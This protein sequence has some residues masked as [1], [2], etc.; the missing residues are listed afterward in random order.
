MIRL[1]CFFQANDG[2]QYKTA[3]QAAIALTEHSQKHEGCIAY[4]V[5]QSATRPDVFLICETWKDLASLDKHSATPEFK[6]YSPMMR[7]CMVMAVNEDLTEL[8]PKIGQDT[9]LIWGDK[10]TAT[11]LSDGKLMEERIPNCGLCILEGCGHFSFLEKPVQFKS[12]MRSYF[13]I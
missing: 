3:L 4:D 10:D 9:L 12:I 2:E 5:F 8:L 13:Q 6:K 11:P 7:Q 1:N